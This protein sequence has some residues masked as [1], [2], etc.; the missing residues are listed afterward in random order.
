MKILLVQY[1]NKIYN[2]RDK[3]QKIS[4]EKDASIKRPAVFE[5]PNSYYSKLL[6]SFKST[7]V[8]EKPSAEDIMLLRMQRKAKKAKEKATKIEKRNARLNPVLVSTINE[9]TKEI[10]ILAKASFP[11]N[12]LS[13]YKREESPFFVDG[14]PCHS[15]EGFLQSLKVPNQNIQK[16]LCLKSGA[17]A[18]HEGRVRSHSYRWQDTQKL[19]WNGE[20]YDRRSP[21]YLELVKKAFYARFN[22]SQ[23]YRDALKATLG[24]TLKH[25]CG[26]DDPESTVLT[27]EEFVSI[28]NELRELDSF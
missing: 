24:Y 7:N 6:L 5:T 11:A 2:F 3:K 20:E 8:G 14:I 4:T 22:H 18:R 21:K 15:L 12:I 25:S 13:N 28:L 9:D 27:E 23:E 16:E 17:S 10:D 26:S 1:P 19:Y